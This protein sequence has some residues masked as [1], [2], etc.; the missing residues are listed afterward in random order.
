M[1]GKLDGELVKVFGVDYEGFM[2]ILLYML[3]GDMVCLFILVLDY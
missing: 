2:V 3:S 1:V